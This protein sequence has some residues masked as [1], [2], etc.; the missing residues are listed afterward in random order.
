MLNKSDLKIK[1]HSFSQE[2]FN[3]IYDAQLDKYTTTP[4]PDNLGD[5]Y[6]AE[7]Y[8]S[9]TDA[10][11]GFTD[12]LYHSVKHFMLNRK[13]KLISKY[14][15]KG[16]LL[17]IGAGTGDFLKSA[18]KVGWEVSGIEPSEAARK[19]SLKK[20]ITL[21][22]S[23]HDLEDQKFEVISMWHVLE[24]VPDTEKQIQW[25]FN[26]LTENGI[27]IIAVPNFKSY[28]AQHYKEFWA[29][30]D[31]PRHL[32]HFSSK[33]IRLLFERNGFTCIAQKPLIFDSFYV[34]MLS[35]KYMGSN[36]PLILGFF[37]G[38]VSNMKALA[39]GQYSSLIYILKKH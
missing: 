38:L 33:S 13:L 4:V 20:G 28:D 27:A 21:F 11:T 12:K 30:W 2:E 9:H 34:S 10:K 23:E 36:F 8:I 26:H 19:N 1:D 6:K 37:R 24:H 35:E 5:Y 7:N 14:A 25:I 17:D 31:V 22:E 16:K 32:H 15:S 29:A 3:L 18:K 39:N